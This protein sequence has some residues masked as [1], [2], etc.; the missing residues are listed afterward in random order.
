MKLPSW[1]KARF[2]RRR[3]NG[4]VT[5]H[6]LVNGTRVAECVTAREAWRR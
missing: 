3:D 2:G 6:L 1:M 5:V 4:T